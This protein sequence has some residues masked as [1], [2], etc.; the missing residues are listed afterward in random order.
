M[1]SVAEA[2]KMLN[3]SQAEYLGYQSDMAAANKRQED[4]AKLTEQLVPVMDSLKIAFMKIATSLGF[5]ITPLAK[6][7]G[8]LGQY[9]DV[10]MVAYAAMKLTTIISI[11][12]NS[13]QM[14]YIHNGKS[15]LVFM[16]A[17]SVSLFR[18]TGLKKLW[19]AVSGMFSGALATN[20]TGM[21][22]FGVATNFTMGKLIIFLSI[23]GALLAV[24]STRFNPVFVAAFHFM[25]TGV[26]MLG[27]AFNT[28]Q[29]PAMLAMLVFSLMVATLA[30]FV[31]TLKELI[32][33]LVDSGA[34]LYTAALGLYAVAGGLAAIGLAMMAL[35]PVGLIGLITLATTMYMMGE[36]FE[37]T[38]SGL[39]RISKMSNALSNLGNNGLI[40]IKSEGNTMTAMMGA[41]DVFQNFNAGKI[42][43]E[44][45]MPDQQTPKIDLT[46]E[47]MGNPLTTLIKK[48]VGGAG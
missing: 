45:K 34:G 21:T 31:Y 43:V 2:Q 6:I 28:I 23:M 15:V 13:A 41:G 19:I 47:L 46:V 24:F 32:V 38:A 9:A 40:A 25:A 39:E 7:I 1:G 4:L 20:A 36:G 10:L 29:G 12:M 35:G 30:L 14:A 5:I 33:T 17:L 3:M 48:V 44:V 11:A 37:K 18:Q 27:A 22:I 16:K 8:F 26:M 42:E